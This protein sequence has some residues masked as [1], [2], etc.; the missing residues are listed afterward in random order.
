MMAVPPIPYVDAVAVA[1][2]AVSGVAWE[3]TTPRWRVDRCRRHARA[4]WRCVGRVELEQPDGTFTVYTLRVRVFGRDEID[5]TRV[6][7]HH[8]EAHPS[9]PPC[10]VRH[11]NVDR[12]LP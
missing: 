7:G 11:G 1:A 12:C 9:V 8:D 4:D 3:N 6:A 5:D 2:A 10:R